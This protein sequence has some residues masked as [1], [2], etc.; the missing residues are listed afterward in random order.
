MLAAVLAVCML[1][2]PV[3]AE[4]ATV[5]TDST[6]EPAYEELALMDSA[7]E[8]SYDAPALTENARMRRR[9]RMPHRERSRL[10]CGRITAHIC[11]ALGRGALDRR[12]S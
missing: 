6:Q 2:M 5:W 1:S 12:K 3:L 7:Q 11:P 9:L 10:L 4:D 8:Q